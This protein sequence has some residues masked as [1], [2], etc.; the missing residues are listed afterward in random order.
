VVRPINH[1][2]YVNQ[3]GK[4]DHYTQDTSLDGNQTG[5]TERKNCSEVIATLAGKGEWGREADHSF[6]DGKLVPAGNTV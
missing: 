3:Q 4:E 6:K 5:W 2:G 1:V